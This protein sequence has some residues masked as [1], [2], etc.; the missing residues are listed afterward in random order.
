MT[1]IRPGESL[2]ALTWKEKKKKENERKGLEIGVSLFIRRVNWAWAWR[3]PS[4]WQFRV[5]VVSISQEICSSNFFSDSSQFGQ[6]G[7]IVISWQFSCLKRTKTTRKLLRKG[8]R[9]FVLFFGR[10]WSHNFEKFVVPGRHNRSEKIFSV[11][12][13]LLCK[14]RRKRLVWSPQHANKTFLAF[15]SQS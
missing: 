8:S 10:V 14:V 3:A 4:Y 6:A 15:S 13:E 9:F 12:R 1:T 5:E 7:S 2:N 11:V